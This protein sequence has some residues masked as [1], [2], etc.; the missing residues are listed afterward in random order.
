MTRAPRTYELFDPVPRNTSSP[1]KDVKSRINFVQK[2]ID[3]LH[4]CVPHFRSIHEVGATLPEECMMS[5][6]CDVPMLFATFHVLIANPSV[7]YSWRPGQAYKNYKR[8]LQLLQQQGGEEK[9]WTLK[10]PVHLGLLEFLVEGFPD[11]R[12]VW[13][14]RE[15]KQAVGR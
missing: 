1:L 14:H 2:A 7:S 15:P 8:V 4:M 6:G 10:C 12:V 5:M 11:A 9:R 3:Q 13:T